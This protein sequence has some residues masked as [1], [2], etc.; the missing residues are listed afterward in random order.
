MPQ[1]LQAAPLAQD[2]RVKALRVPLF[3]V[4]CR[5]PTILLAPF[6]RLSL[7]QA[8]AACLPVYSSPTVKLVTPPINAC[9][10]LGTNKPY[11]RKRAFAEL[12]NTPP[13]AYWR[14]THG[15]PTACAAPLVKVVGIDSDSLASA[16]MVAALNA[17]DQ[18][19]KIAY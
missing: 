10:Q 8:K 9:G 4:S 14:T 18:L 12:A 17:L 13:A 15:D 11:Q 16:S 6:L 5:C 19:E 2:A 3:R 1:V 7:N